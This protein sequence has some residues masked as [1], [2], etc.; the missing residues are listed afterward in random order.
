MGNR[1]RRGREPKKPKKAKEQR[2]PA[3][4]RWEPT[5][6][7]PAPTPSRRRNLLRTCPKAETPDGVNSMTL[8]RLLRLS[9]MVFRARAAAAERCSENLPWI[10]K[11]DALI[12]GGGAAGLMCAAEA[13][14]RGRRVAVIEHADRAGQ[15]NPHLRRRPM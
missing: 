10:D 1:D 13:G 8:R 7:R 11:F 12:L 15:E 2:G 5:P 3:K 4:S 14:K 6:P 9:L